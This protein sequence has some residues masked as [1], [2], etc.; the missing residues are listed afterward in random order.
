[1]NSLYKAFHQ[2]FEV[3]IADTPELLEKVFRI[4]YQMLC[5]DM[6]VPGYEP[7]LYPDGLERDDYDCHSAH[8]LIRFRPSGEFIGTVRLIMFDPKNPEKLFPI[9]QNTQIDPALFILNKPL[10]QQTGEISRFII[11]KG[12]DRRK[13]ERRSI[14]DTEATESS[15]KVIKSRDK[16][17]RR[18]ST[19]KDRRAI[20]DL[21]LVLAAGTIR[22]SAQYGISNWLTI[23]DP[24]LNRL[25]GYYGLDMKAIG[26]LTDHYGIRRPYFL[27]GVK[28]MKKI[29]QD[30][31]DVWEMI[32]EDG[33]FGDLTS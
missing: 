6:N 5:I 33:K 22:I 32:T 9:E 7:S 30:H 23:M 28:M 16:A 18:S 31:I 27:D 11:I 29:K 2:Y 24:A 8:V 1:M 17:D 10:R 4:R 3:V 19:K 14:T 26:P 13:A 25:L 21:T 15:N 20:R 12:F